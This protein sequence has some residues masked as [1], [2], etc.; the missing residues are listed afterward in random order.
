MINDQ[1][2]NGRGE[3]QIDEITYAWGGYSKCMHGRTR[4]E[5]LVINGWPQTNVL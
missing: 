5:K 3:Y 1:S 4:A 2:Q